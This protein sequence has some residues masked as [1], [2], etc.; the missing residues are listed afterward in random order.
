[1]SI[2][3]TICYLVNYIYFLLFNF[4]VHKKCN[5]LR[6]SGAIKNSQNGI[7]KR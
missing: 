7:K 6:T 5:F 3:I 2:T 1:M 4:S